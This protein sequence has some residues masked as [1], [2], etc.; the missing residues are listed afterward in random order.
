MDS[1]EQIK[2]AMRLFLRAIDGQ[3]WSVLE[4]LLHPAAEYEVSGYM[5]FRGR[6]NVLNYYRNIRLIA[7][8]EHIIES[9]V[10]EGD[11]GICWGRF[12]GRQRDGADITMLFADIMQ[13]ENRK[14]RKRRVYL[15]EPKAS[16]G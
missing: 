5:P 14:V 9:I 11:R 7:R 12:V 1:Q 4:A 2:T 15:C 6:D 3:D 8:G 10:V 16:A 13:F